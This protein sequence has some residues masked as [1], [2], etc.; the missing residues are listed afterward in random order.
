MKMLLSEQHQYTLA[1]GSNMFES[2]FDT[3]FAFVRQYLRMLSNSQHNASTSQH[4]KGLNTANDRFPSS[5]LEPPS[6]RVP[7]LHFPLTKSRCT[8]LPTVIVLI[9]KPHLSSFAPSHL[10]FPIQSVHHGPPLPHPLKCY[11]TSNLSS[12]SCSPCPAAILVSTCVSRGV[13]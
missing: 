6:T 13:R 10:Y 8:I 12:R 9:C 2:R 3:H 4:Q 11:A 7:K 5:F 1:L